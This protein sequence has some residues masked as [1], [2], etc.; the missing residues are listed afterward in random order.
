ML[1]GMVCLASCDKTA[2]GQLMAAGALNIPT[3]VVRLRLPA[4]RPL[5]TA[6]TVDIE[7]VFIKAGHVATWAA[8]TVE[9]VVAMSRHAIRGPGVCSG[10]GTANSMHIASEALGMALPGSAP[11]AANSPKM[12]A[13]AC[14]RRGAR[15]VQ[16]VWRRT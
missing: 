6:S 12:W 4:Q 15:I 8:W 13:T 16:M 3:V 2:P 7:E 11:V 1:D 9:D 10:M 5:T 14:A